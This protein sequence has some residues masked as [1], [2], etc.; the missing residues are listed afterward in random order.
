MQAHL[1][2][3]H[4]CANTDAKFLLLLAVQGQH[5]PHG[6]VQKGMI[7]NLQMCCTQIQ[8]LKTTKPHIQYR[9]EYLNFVDLHSCLCYT[10]EFQLQHKTSNMVM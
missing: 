3:F 9:N 10:K 2:I 4:G 7:D 5:Y 6:T 1:N 8:N